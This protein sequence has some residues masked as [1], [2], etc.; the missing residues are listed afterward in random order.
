M[1]AFTKE[2]ITELCSQY[3][4]S[5]KAIFNISM[6]ISA[7]RARL[8]DIN[9]ILN[10]LYLK[11]KTVKEINDLKKICHLFGGQILHERIIDAKNMWSADASSGFNNEQIQFNITRLITAST[12]IGKFIDKLSK[13]ERKIRIAKGD[14]TLWQ[15][16]EYFVTKLQSV[17]R[18]YAQ[19]KKYLEHKCFK[20][21]GL[22]YTQAKGEFE[23]FC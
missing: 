16:K 4:T 13:K 22:G 3:E 9:M 14:F 6:N 11:V 1:A 23:S 10:S 21:G 18:M 5:F 15:D 17:F 20:P 12:L 7:I 2:Q 19:R 8:G